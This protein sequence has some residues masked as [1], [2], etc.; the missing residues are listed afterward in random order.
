[1]KTLC[2]ILLGSNI[3]VVPSKVFEYI[4]IF[5]VRE[6]RSIVGKLDPRA[7]KCI[8]IGYSSRQKE[9]KYLCLTE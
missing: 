1:M 8:F 7:V 2:E 9:Y 4:Y 3:F 6:H 5:F